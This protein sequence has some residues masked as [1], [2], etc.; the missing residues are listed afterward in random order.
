MPQILAHILLWGLV[1]AAN[2]TD[3]AF[4][5]VV[6][7]SGQAFRNETKAGFEREAILIL[8]LLGMVIEGQRITEII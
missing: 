1:V 4:N 8:C 6:V 7:I 5:K 3:I 2:S